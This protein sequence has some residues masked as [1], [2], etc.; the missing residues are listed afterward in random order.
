MKDALIRLGFNPETVD[1]IL[2]ITLEQLRKPTPEMV[3]AGV[4]AMKKGYG[5]IGIFQAMIDEA[6]KG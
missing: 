6:R 1:A 3:N 4:Q 5:I 2:D